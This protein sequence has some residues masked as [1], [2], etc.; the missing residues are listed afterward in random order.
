M[1]ELVA[2]KDPESVFTALGLGSCIGLC[3]YD[4]IAKVAAMAHVVLPSAI[5]NGNGLP[6]KSADAAVPN[7]IAAMVK[8]GAAER[9]IK[10]AIAGGAQIFA[11]RNADMHMDVG[12]RNSDA[13][14][15]LLASRKINLI[16]SDVGG[17][18]GRTVKLY[19]DTGIVG[20]RVAGK[21]EY[22]LAKLAL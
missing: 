4:P 15:N 10:V 8:L 16:A 3:A 9:R 19:V 20:V 7:L 11:F 5:G 17:G 2:S 13:V 21:P 1:G 12:T 18:S 14:T 6:A 22:V